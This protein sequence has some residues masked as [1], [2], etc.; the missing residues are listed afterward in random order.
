[1]K[2]NYWDD[3]SSWLNVYAIV[4]AAAEAEKRRVYEFLKGY[5]GDD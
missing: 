2:K 1:M 5:F 4:Q 3:E